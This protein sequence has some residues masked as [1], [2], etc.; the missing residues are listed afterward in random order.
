[1]VEVEG[2]TGNCHEEKMKNDIADL[3]ARVMKV[4]VNATDAEEQCNN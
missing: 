1:M 2:L 4:M 3:V